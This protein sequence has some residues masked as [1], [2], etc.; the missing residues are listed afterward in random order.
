MLRRS[1][2]RGERRGGRR[3]YKATRLLGGVGGWGWPQSESDPT[4]DD[5]TV[6]NGA[7]KM[8]LWVG[9]PP[10]GRELRTIAVRFERVSR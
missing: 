9:H 7:P 5:E 4:H 6:M 2:K 10:T 1:G 3:D 8:G